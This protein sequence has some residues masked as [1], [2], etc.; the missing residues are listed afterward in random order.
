MNAKSVNTPAILEQNMS[1]LPV[2]AVI[3][4]TISFI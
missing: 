2:Y 4:Y 1:I 3:T